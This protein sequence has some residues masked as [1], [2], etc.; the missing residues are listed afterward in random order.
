MMRIALK[1]EYA[2]GS[3]AETT[4]TAPDLIAFERHYD[5]SMAVFGSDTRIEYILWLT[6]HALNRKK[7]TALDFDAWVDTVDSVTAGDSGE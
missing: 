5:K 1:V 4:A 6:W 7:E 2:D 3:G